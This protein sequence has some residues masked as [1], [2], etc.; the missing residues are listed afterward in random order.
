[1]LAYAYNGHRWAE[2]LATA[3]SKTHMWLQLRRVPELR[4][5]LTPDFPIGC[6][7]ILLS[8]DWLPTLAQPHVE[9]I[10]TPIREITATGVRT[11][12][13]TLREVDAIIYGTGFMATE[14]LAPMEVRGPG[15]RS[16]HQTWTHDVRRQLS[17]LVQNRRGSQHQ[18]LGRLDVRVRAAHARTG[19]GALPA[20][21]RTGFSSAHVSGCGGVRPSWPDRR[22]LSQ[23][24]GW[25]LPNQR[26]TCGA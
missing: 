20:A 3:L 9:V 23:I 11:A 14:F 24:T 2:R 15:G 12:D 13:G 6:K 4:R 19:A 21:G 8:N 22:Q 16:L 10:D 1:M 17:E 5:K 18:Q 25:R 7:R 26:S